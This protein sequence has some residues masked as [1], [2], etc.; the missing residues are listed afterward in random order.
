LTSKSSHRI[1]HT[2]RCSFSD[3]ASLIAGEGG[4]EVTE[5]FVACVCMLCSAN[6][7]ADRGTVGSK[8]FHDGT[9]KTT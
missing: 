6:K 8:Q 2:V 4:F 7:Q 5:G 9:T 1:N 3:A